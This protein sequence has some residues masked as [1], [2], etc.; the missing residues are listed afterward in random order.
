MKGV[1]SSDGSKWDAFFRMDKS[2]SLSDYEDENSLDLQSSASQR[3]SD[4]E[5]SDDDY[6][7]SE[8]ES[9]SESDEESEREYD[10][11]AE[12]K[13]IKKGRFGLRKRREKSYYNRRDDEDDEDESISDERNRNNRAKPTKSRGKPT[14]NRGKPTKTRDKSKSVNDEV[15]DDNKSTSSVFKNYVTMINS[16]KGDTKELTLIPIGG[17]TQ[18][19]YMVLTPRSDFDNN[20]PPHVLSPQS[21]R[22]ISL[23]KGLS[24][25][26]T[27]K[28]QIFKV[29]PKKAHE[30]KQFLKVHPKKLEE[31]YE[32]LKS[33]TKARLEG[34]SA[35]GHKSTNGHAFG[36]D[37]GMRDLNVPPPLFSTI[38][39]L[40]TG[41]TSERGHDDTSEEEY[42]N[43]SLFNNE[44][45][46]SVRKKKH[47]LEYLIS[48]SSVR[49]KS[50]SDRGI[51]VESESIQSQE[52]AK[53]DASFPFGKN[54]SRSSSSSNNTGFS[55]QVDEKKFSQKQDELDGVDIAANPPGKRS[56]SKRNFSMKKFFKFGKTKDKGES[57]ID[58]KQ[59]NSS[60]SQTQLGPNRVLSMVRPPVKSSEFALLKDNDA[61]QNEMV[62]FYYFG[63]EAK[64]SMDHI[65]KKEELIPGPNS[66]EVLI[67]VEV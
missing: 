12:N 56:K 28:K 2:V 66:E 38:S 62:V 34:G 52:K 30:K 11:D 21:I 24:N 23:K 29:K 6:E 18:A 27:T 10:S 37:E 32:K 51:F 36:Y 7:E 15:D 44:I 50:G 9:E 48:R 20:K 61:I 60:I 39:N 26:S 67:Q 1:A 54:R 8:S 59:S 13:V 5:V 31:K 19:Q 47:P 25:T 53:P 64:K 33:E 41:S 43:D 42:E 45:E 58:L 63:G 40:V 49:S 22:S 57:S 16:A 14:K 35:T 3:F 65:K 46:D 4:S 17:A 55:K